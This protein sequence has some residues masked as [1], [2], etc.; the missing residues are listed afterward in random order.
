VNATQRHERLTRL[1]KGCRLSL[2]Q[3]VTIVAGAYAG[4]SGRLVR[5]ERRWVV[6]LDQ[7]TRDRLRGAFGGPAAVYAKGL[8][9]AAYT[10]P[11]SARPESVG[12]LQSHVG[13]SKQ[14]ANEAQPNGD[15][16]VR[17]VRIMRPW[18]EPWAPSVPPD[19]RPLNFGALSHP[20]REVG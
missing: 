12:A 13:N 3:R 1:S 17:L 14:F 16:T 11:E 20:A 4:A 2:G 19:A 15:G 5:V 7:E 18:P 8:K 6:D 9:L 10:V